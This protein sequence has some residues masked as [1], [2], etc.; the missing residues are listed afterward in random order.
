LDRID[1]SREFIHFRGS[2]P[3]LEI[4]RH[5]AEANLC[6]FASSCENMPNILL[7]GMT[8]GLP[9]ACSKC[10]P[11]PEILGPSG[12]YFDPENPNEIASA[13]KVLIENPK[14]RSE[15]ACA[16]YSKSQAYSWER[17]A[18]E[19]FSFLSVLARNSKLN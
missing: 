4:H 5:Y 7:E 18:D 6:I 19:T 11:M 1:P 9:I 12:I 17:C 14:L 16:S 2:V 13:L 8:S 10:G 3:Y 15:K